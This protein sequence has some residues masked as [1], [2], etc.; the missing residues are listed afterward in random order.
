MKNIRYHRKRGLPKNGPFPFLRLKGYIYRYFGIYLARKEEHAYI[1][2][3]DGLR[4]MNELSK[5]LR[6]QSL[7]KGIAIGEWQL[8]YGFIRPLSP[9]RFN[10]PTW[11]WKPVAHIHESLQAV[12]ND[13]KK[14][15]WKLRHKW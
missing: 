1:H 9:Y 4:A 12:K 3:K 10:E 14:L 13:L 5:A 8:D 7:A 11:L 6:D 15:L 2:S